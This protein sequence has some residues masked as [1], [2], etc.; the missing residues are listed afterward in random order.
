MTGETIAHFKLLEKLGK[1]GMGEVYRARDMRLARDVALKILP[2]DFASDR[3]RVARFQREARAASALNHPHIVS[4]HDSG[5]EDSTCFIAMELVDGEPLTAWV[6]AERP[7]LQRL[8][9][10]FQQIADALAVAHEAGIVHR[11]LKPG[12]LLVTRQGYVKI[13]D[14]GIAK[15]IAGTNAGDAT[16][17]GGGMTEHGAIVGTLAY[18]SPEQARGETVDCRSDLF[19]LGTVLYEALAGRRPFDA[20][21]NVDT[22]YAIVHSDPP[23]LRRFAPDLPPDLEWVAEKALTRNR[24][25]RYQSARELAADFGRVRRR[26]EM[27]V[28]MPADAP[29]RSHPFAWGF[30]A[31]GALLGVILTGSLVLLPPV[32][33]KL[34][35]AP[36]GLR[37]ETQLRAL[38]SDPGYEGEPTFTPDGRSLAYVS[39]R[40]GNFE[41]FLRQ[42]S[43]GP[44]VNLTQDP[45]ND[46]QP[47]FSPDGKQIAFV[48]DRTGAPLRYPSPDSEILGGEIYVMTTLGGVPRRVAAGNFP[49]WSPDGK[50][51]AF[52]S[53]LWFERRLFQVAA[54]GGEPHPIP[55]SFEGSVD[56]GRPGATPDIY[57]PAYSPDGRWIA[58]DAQ[59]NIYIMPAEGGRAVRVARGYHAAWIANPL[60]LVFTSNEPGS[61][62]SLRI[63]AV[64]PAGGRPSG[65][66]EPLTIGRGL[67]TAAAISMDGTEVAFAALDVSANVEALPFD[68][69]TGLV[70]GPAEALT[71]GND[72]IYFAS[73]APQGSAIVYQAHRTPTIW[74]KDRG[75]PANQLSL[76]PS[77]ADFYPRWAP[78]GRSIAF[79]RRPVAALEG[80]SILWLMAPDGANPRSLGRTASNGFL[81][82]TPGARSLLIVD[83]G[84][85][86]LYR[87]DLASGAS[88]KLTNEAGLL[89]ISCMSPDGAW[90]A[91]Q[92]RQSTR[93]NVVIRALPVAGSMTSPSRVVVD[94]G[95]RDENAYHPFFSPSG[96]WLYFTPDHRN[97]YQVPGPAQNWRALPAERC[98]KFPDSGLYMEDPQA[99]H[100]GRRLMYS[101]RRATADLWIMTIRVH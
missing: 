30:L 80:S 41:I 10:V 36:S 28:L 3:E 33:S 91:F 43:G 45:A 65:V 63:E 7:D 78:D 46:V 47:A 4:I 20:E 66:S 32:R 31:A 79:S 95:E 81:A 74:R 96:R 40:T 53:G 22:L 54:T 26:L 29:S 23:L 64:S 88:T 98:T 101:R 35:P 87:F 42:V 67:D 100:D 70:L 84:D 72:V 5:Q 85:G 75:A 56:P 58:F 11:D 19:S 82:W 93:G 71:S 60:A 61:M 94:L 14:F 50:R 9:G 62:G 76:D 90:I 6:K 89:P 21:T 99:T 2:P 55:V 49:G 68:F 34:A 57:H 38:T 69:E 59:Q 17:P 48:S 51:L 39:D 97:I 16:L 18:M 44:D 77:Q 25:E 27:S 37:V 13:V 52:V 1:G 73:D 15:I 86:Q 12:N 24:D 8:L 92:S 83:P